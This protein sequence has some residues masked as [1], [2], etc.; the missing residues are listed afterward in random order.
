MDDT[1]QKNEIMQSQ[2]LLYTG[3]EGNVTAQVYFKDETF[4]MTQKTMGEVFGTTTDNIGLHLKNIY[5]ENELDKNST[6]EE[7]SVIQKEGNRAV[8]RKILFY[9]L[10]AIIAVGYRVNSKKATQFR[11][12]ATNTLKEYIVKGFVMNDEMLKNGKPFGQDY[13]DELLERI[14]IIRTSERRFYQK[15][16]D[17]FIECSID[18]DKDSEIANNFFATI[19]NKFHYAITSH[20]AAEIIY[21]RVDSKKEYMGLTSWKDSP[22][23]KILKNDVSIAKNYLAEEEIKGLNN[24]VNIFLDVAESKAQEGIV[25]R[26]EDWERQVTKSLLLLDKKILEGKGSISHEQAKEKAENEYDKFKVIQDK[27]YI[28]DFDKLIVETKLIEDKKSN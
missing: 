17:L 1:K 15:I 27:K 10:D 5:E 9:N 6:A 4:W 23:G 3:L 20:T 11:I 28:S 19:Q 22:H 26:M 13:F 8:N 25:M 2:I 16:T 24:L 14:K 12:W 21:E 7:I 18:Y